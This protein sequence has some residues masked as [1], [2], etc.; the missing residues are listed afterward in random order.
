MEHRLCF[1]CQ[2]VIFNAIGHSRRERVARFVY[3]SEVVARKPDIERLMVAVYVRIERFYLAPSV[4]AVISKFAAL[5]LRRYGSGKNLE[6]YGVILFGDKV[7]SACSGE[8][9]GKAI[10]ARVRR[11]LYG[12]AY[13]AAVKPDGQACRLRAKFLAGVFGLRRPRYA[14]EIVFRLRNGEID[15]EVQLAVV[16]VAGNGGDRI[17]LPGR[18]IHGRRY[19]LPFFCIIGISHPAERRRARRTGRRVA[20]SPALNNGRSLPAVFRA[21]YAPRE[22]DEFVRAVRPFIVF[23]ILERDDYFV[24]ARIGGHKPY[25]RDACDFERE[26]V[27]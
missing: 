21:V 9:D 15:A 26:S 5:P 18:R 12:I 6:L 4:F 1:F 10:F 17:V 23:G 11:A 22:R 20:V 13:R 8:G 3:I 14:A 2:H 16:T 7:V 19:R 24:S 27:H 25:A